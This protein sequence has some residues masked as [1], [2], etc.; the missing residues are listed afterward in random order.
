MPTGIKF[1]FQKVSATN[2]RRHCKGTDEGGYCDGDG[3]AF[4]D[5]RNNA[6]QLIISRTLSF[7]VMNVCI[8]VYEDQNCIVDQLLGFCSYIFL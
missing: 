1:P 4:G 3:N 8:E 5:G 7:L 6:N 2:G